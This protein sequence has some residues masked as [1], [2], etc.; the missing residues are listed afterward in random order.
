MKDDSVDKNFSL[1][2]NIDNGTIRIF[3]KGENTMKRIVSLVLACVLLLG[4]VFSLA[5]CATMLM[6]TYTNETLKTTYEFS[7]NKV[8]KK[9]PSL[10]G[11]TTVYEGTYEIKEDAENEGKYTITFTWGEDAD[12]EEDGGVALPFSQGEKDGTKYIEILGIKYTKQ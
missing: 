6:G 8:T 3:I 9:T 2:H 10:L 1:W 12:K 11:G 4:C 7:G 5:S